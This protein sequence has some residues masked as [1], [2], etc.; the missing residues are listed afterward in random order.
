MKKRILLQFK[1]TAK[2]LKIKKHTAR[3]SAVCKIS[4]GLV[5]SNTTLTL[6]MPLT[7]LSFLV[8][9]F[10]SM[11]DSARSTIIIT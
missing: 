11:E 6:F 10:K 2:I 3:K 9:S 1:T 5:Y 7:C 4:E 8:S